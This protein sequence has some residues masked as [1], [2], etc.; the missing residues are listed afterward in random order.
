[1]STSRCHSW[2][3]CLSPFLCTLP[4]STVTRSPSIVAVRPLRRMLGNR[5]DVTR[6]FLGD[7]CCISLDISSVMRLAVY[8]LGSATIHTKRRQNWSREST[9]TLTKSQRVYTQFTQSNRNTT[10]SK[11]QCVWC[12]YMFA[13]CVHVCSV[14]V[15]VYVRCMCGV[16][17]YMGCVCVWACAIGWS[18]REAL[19]WGQFFA[20]AVRSKDVGCQACA[21]TCWVVSLPLTQAF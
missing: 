21:L 6:S 8:E 20:S 15:C 7:I 16:Y 14:C 5:S 1:M 17:V 2:F 11:I 9:H 12:M 3:F 4:L 18:Q 10:I 13:L 19:E